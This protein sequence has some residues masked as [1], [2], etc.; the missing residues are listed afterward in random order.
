MAIFTTHKFTKSF[1]IAN[2]DVVDF[3]SVP[4]YR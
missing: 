3:Q 4:A 1:R 2:G